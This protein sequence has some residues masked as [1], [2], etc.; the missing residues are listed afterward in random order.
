VAYAPGGSTDILAR[1]L[2]RWLSDRLG[3]PLIIENRPG[4]AS[5]VGTEMVVRAQPDGY[6]LLMV[7]ASPSIN[8]TL[9]EK[10]TFNFGRDLAPIACIL[11]SPLVMVV[12]PAVPATTVP[13][14]INYAKAN[15]GKV[16]MASAGTGNT[17]HIAGELFKMMTGVAMTHVPYRGGGPAVADLLGGQV[18]VTFSGVAVSIELIRA[19]KL[20]PLA[21]TTTTPLDALPAV[22]PLAEFVKGYEAIQWYG[23]LAPKKTPA[24]IVEKLNTEI[25][26][27]LA[28]PMMKAR[29]AEQGGGRVFTGSGADFGKLIA[30][31]TEK[32][33][34]VVRFAGI[35]PD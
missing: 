32:W 28:D 6:T 25:N 16:N 18:Q 8:A 17:G 30:E 35:K 21:V 20:R 4:A 26:T 12:N 27:A 13:E 33:A 9:Y 22:P 2:G 7:D 34:K 1:S 11:Q 15:P 5:N 10:L 3:Q 24:S 14:F 29:L 31:D 23:L 19:G